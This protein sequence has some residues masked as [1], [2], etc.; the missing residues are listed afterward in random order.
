[1]SEKRRMQRFFSHVL[2]EAMSLFT[3]T[4]LPFSIILMLSACTSPAKQSVSKSDVYGEALAGGRKGELERLLRDKLSIWQGVRYRFG[5]ESSRG[6]DCSAF[7]MKVYEELFGIPLPRTSAEQA[8]LGYR[9]SEAEIEAGDLVFFKT[10][11]YPYHVG[12][13]LSAG[14]FVHA[15]SSL[16]VAVANLRSGYWHRYFWT[17]KRIPFL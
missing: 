12:I 1:M 15:S 6:V 16:G 8:V 4:V 9:V 14:E 10:P 13:Y 5:G 3:A 11:S 7:V 2:W 17:A